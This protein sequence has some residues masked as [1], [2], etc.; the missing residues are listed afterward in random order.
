MDLEN[1]DNKT[2]EIFVGEDLAAMSIEELE[3]RV[4]ILSQEI[5]RVKAEIVNKKL[6]MNDAEA[7]FKSQ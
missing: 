1:T 6:K 7:V 4:D 2:G 5:A 3:K